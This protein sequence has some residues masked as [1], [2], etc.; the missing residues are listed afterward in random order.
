M[1]GSI[2][3]M[4]DSRRCIWRPERDSGRDAGVHGRV[5]E[6]L[7][8]DHDRVRAAATVGLLRRNLPSNEIH[9]VRSGC[10]A[11]EFFRGLA[12]HPVPGRPSRPVLA[13]L[14]EDLSGMAGHSILGSML[15][16][17]PFGA[18]LV[19]L[20]VESGRIAAHR[21]WRPEPD[22]YLEKPFAFA[23]LRERLRS[24]GGA[25]A[26]A[27]TPPRARPAGQSPPP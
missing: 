20:L 24:F 18:R 9:V 25:A 26:S 16:I 21:Q 5:A 12:M 7:L 22:G 23:K 15:R 10:E 8:G 13:L 27:W 4:D 19:I 3:W 14:D 2:L 6:V 11:L 17:P 1:A